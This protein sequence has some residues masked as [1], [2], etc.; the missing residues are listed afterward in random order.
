MT[1]ECKFLQKYEVKKKLKFPSTMTPHRGAGLWHLCGVLAVW[2]WIRS[3]LPSADDAPAATAYVETRTSQRTD[4]IQ[5]V[6]PQVLQ[7]Q[8]QKPE[9][10]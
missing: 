6:L 8:V 7:Q 3:F 9:S 4:P 1:P 2:C 10:L 5:A